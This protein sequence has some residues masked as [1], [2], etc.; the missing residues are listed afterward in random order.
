MRVPAPVSLFALAAIAGLFAPVPSALA[1]DL[2]MADNPQKILEIAR[3]Y[4]SA[5]LET[6]N[7]GDP[8]IRARMDGTAYSILFFGCEAGAN[9]TSIQF[10]TYLPPPA[11]PIVAVNVWN[12]DLRF[13]K[14]YVDGDGDVVIEMDVNLWGGVAAK[15]LDDTFDWWR[16]VL[17]RAGEEFAAAPGLPRLPLAG[18]D[19]TSL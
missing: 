2:V 17:E 18:A 12:R 7:S 8:R 10:W 13:A 15:N 5:E 11:D 14:A 16:A 4:G 19:S 9:C 6:D 3:G 1:Q